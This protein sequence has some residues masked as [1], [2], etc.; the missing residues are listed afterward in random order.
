MIWPS[1]V[2]LTGYPSSG[3]STLSKYLQKEYDFTVISADDLRHSM[4]GEGYFN[5]KEL[6]NGN[7]KEDLVWQMIGRGKMEALNRGLDVLIDTTAMVDE[8]R[9]LHLDTTIPYKGSLI[10][11]KYLLWVDTDRE[12]IGERNLKRGRSNDPLKWWDEHW[13]DPVLGNDNCLLLRLRNNTE[14]DLQRIYDALDK[15]FGN[16]KVRT[17]N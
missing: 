7:L 12:V 14:E 3:K 1:L 5:L 13:T 10:A 6:P 16:K 2:V 8:V 11:N 9:Y 15:E 17:K 4:F